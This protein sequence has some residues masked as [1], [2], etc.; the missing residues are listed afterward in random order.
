MSTP[1]G[2]GYANFAERV[3]SDFVMHL[4]DGGQVPLVLTDCT[5]GSPHSFS[6]SFKAGPRAPREQQL[7]QLTAAGF[8]PELVFLVPVAFRPNDPEFPLE[9]QAIFNFIPGQEG[10]A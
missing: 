7:Y 8:G 4:P 5:A 1:S 2:P 3:G 6:L 9:Y 10:S